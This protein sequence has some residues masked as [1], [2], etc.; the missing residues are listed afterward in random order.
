MEPEN[1]GSTTVALKVKSVSFLDDSVK[2]GTLSRELSK[3][4]KD[5][6]NVLVAMLES[7]DMRLRFQAATK[8]LEFDI[9]VKKAISSDQIQRVI[10]EIKLNG[11]SGSKTLTLDDDKAKRPLVDFGTIRSIS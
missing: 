10:A 8:L 3:S 2:L 4:S 6:I 11:A 7:Q 1:S 5:A 9:D